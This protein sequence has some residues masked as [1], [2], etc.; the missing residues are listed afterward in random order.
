MTIDEWL[1]SACADADRR[2]LP[3][4]KTLLSSLAGAMRTLR[5]ADWNDN[6]D[7]RPGPDRP[8]PTAAGGQAPGGT[9]PRENGGGR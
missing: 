8:T 6:A 7:G 2:E 5:A 3:E 4:L 1:T 9:T